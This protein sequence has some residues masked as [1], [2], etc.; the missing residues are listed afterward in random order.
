MGPGTGVI[1]SA[2][3][4]ENNNVTLLEINDQ[5]IQILKAKFPSINIIHGDASVLEQYI[6]KSVTYDFIVSSTPLV[7][8]KKT[9]TYPILQQFSKFFNWRGLSYAVFLFT[10]L[11]TGK[12]WF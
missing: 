11:S 4:V 3:L 5:F 1:T 8:M 10:F 12:C 2:L 7:F 9:K 6:D